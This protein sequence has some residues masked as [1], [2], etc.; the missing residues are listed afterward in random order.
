MI[1]K[2]FDS[3]YI[4]GIYTFAFSLS[5]AVSVFISSAQNVQIPMV[6]KLLANPS[7]DSEK[8]INEI[9][10]IFHF[11]TVSAIVVG[12]AVAAVFIKITFA[13]EYLVIVEYIGILFFAYI[14]RTYYILFADSLF[15]FKKTKLIFLITLC[16]FLIGY[17]CMKL[18]IP[19]WGI[20]GVCVSVMIINFSQCIGAIL[21]IKFCKLNTGLYKM[22]INHLY[23]FFILVA[24]FL[25][26]YLLI[27]A[28]LQ[29]IYC[30]FFPTFVTLLFSIYFF[31]KKRTLIREKARNL[32]GKYKWLNR[33]A[34]LVKS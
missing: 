28:D 14:F 26:R 2:S 31:Y 7:R 19:V 20:P 6:Y 30:N 29:V 23:T 11:I 18:L 5:G 17:A 12:L 25:S 34:F 4:L 22:N 10:K 15:Y 21:L 8:K 27:Q 13:K 1:E 32:K 9:V 33:F 16:S 24:Y 3:S